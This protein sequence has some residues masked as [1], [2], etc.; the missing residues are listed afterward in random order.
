MQI[1]D[2]QSGAY[3]EPRNLSFE[4]VTVC[5]VGQ[6]HCW[7]ECSPLNLNAP[8]IPGA[9]TFL[10]QEAR[11]LVQRRARHVSLAFVPALIYESG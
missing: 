11:Y 3:R 9:F 2:D 10:Q 5:I 4:S 8:V 7:T 6:N 1:P